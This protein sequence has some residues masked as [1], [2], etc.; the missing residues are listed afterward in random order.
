MLKRADKQPLGSFTA[1]VLL[2]C[3]FDVCLTSA[4]SFVFPEIHHRGNKHS[5]YA[6]ISIYKRFDSINA[7]NV[8]I[9]C[10][11]FDIKYITVLENKYKICFKYVGFRCHSS[12]RV[13]RWRLS[14][15][16]WFSNMVSRRVTFPINT[17][18]NLETTTTAADYSF[19]QL[20]LLAL[21][22]LNSTDDYTARRQH[23]S[24]MSP[25]SH[26]T[27]FIPA[28]QFRDLFAC[29]KFA[30]SCLFVGLRPLT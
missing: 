15:Q 27:L 23:V 25:N 2:P 11:S 30:W 1:A 24:P 19:V 26:K 12:R 14:L 29:L 18:T 20:L 6:F 21:Q 3:R 17:G 9:C 13:D 4:M 16:P 10:C 28:R 22:N 5:Y 7:E 8:M